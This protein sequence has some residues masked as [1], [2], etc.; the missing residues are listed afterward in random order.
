MRVAGF[1][2]SPL[3]FRGNGT[4]LAILLELPPKSIEALGIL[5]S[6]RS[7]L[8]RELQIHCMQDSFCYDIARAKDYLRSYTC[9]IFD[10]LKKHYSTKIDTYSYEH[11][12]GAEAVNIVLACWNDFDPLIKAA[13]WEP[14]LK[15]SLDE[16]VGRPLGGEPATVKPEQSA[17]PIDSI[18]AKGAGSN[19][20]AGYS[21]ELR[22]LLVECRWRPEDIAEKIKIQP[23]NVYRHLSGKTTPTLANIARYEEAFSKKLNR[24]IKLKTSVKGQ[25]NVT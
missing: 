6:K 5:T 4:A 7:S 17:P 13:T 25:Y 10:F 8:K 1:I 23:R 22:A 19:M 2:V 20:G 18:T 15:R 9:S 11:L 14:T 16:H 21:E 3:L 12:I 24:Q